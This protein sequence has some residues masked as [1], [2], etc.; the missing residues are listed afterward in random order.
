MKL[1]WSCLGSHYVLNF[2]V[3]ISKGHH[4]WLFSHLR[5]LGKDKWVHICRAERLG[6]GVVM[7]SN[8]DNQQLWK[9]RAHN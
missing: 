8:L 2:Q 1:F 5:L 9:M 6:G 7:C 3:I 4:H